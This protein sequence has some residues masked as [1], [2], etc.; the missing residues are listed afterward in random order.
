MPSCALNLS[1]LN[2]ASTSIDVKR[3]KDAGFYSP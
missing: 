2:L 3:T 1:L